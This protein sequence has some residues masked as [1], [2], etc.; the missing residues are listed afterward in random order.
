MRISDISQN[1]LFQVTGIVLAVLISFIGIRMLAYWRSFVFRPGRYRARA[2]VTTSQLRAT[3]VPFVK[4]QWTTKGGLGSTEVILRGLRQ[5]EELAR[6]DPGFYRRF[7][8][9]EVVTENRE[10]ARLIEQ[11]FA[12][13]PL[14]PPTCVVTPADYETPNGTQLKA[15]QMHY[16][17]ELRRMGHNRKP[18]RTFIIHFDEDTLMVPAEFRKMIA[19]LAYTDKSLLTGPIYYP[20]EYD[21]AS[22]L[23]RA[24]EASRPIT[25]FECRHVM[26][27]GVPLHIHGSNLAVEETFENRLGWDIGLV[28]GVPFVAEDYMF[29]MDAF[30]REGREAFGWHGCVALE[31]PPFSF[32]SVFRQRYRWVF[33]VLQGMSVDTLLPDFAKLPRRLRMKVIWGTRY[34]IAT[35]AAGSFVGALALVYVPFWLAVA[36]SNMAAGK[37]IGI[38][39]KLAAWFALV[40]FM[41]LGSNIVG[42]WANTLDAGFPALRRVTEITRAVSI[43]PFV[44]MME[45]L[46]ALKAVVQWMAG[47]R[48]MHW[49]VT[50]STKAADDV[51]NGRSEHSGRPLAETVTEALVPWR[52]APAQ[53]RLL[54]A[55]CST[56]TAVLTVSVYLGMPLLAVAQAVTLSLSADALFAASGVIVLVSGILAVIWRTSRP[57]AAHSRRRPAAHAVR[58]PQPTIL[59]AAADAETAS[60]G[61]QALEAMFQVRS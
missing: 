17:T 46:A 1:A 26:E 25:C 9:A 13:S 31:Q 6:E 19:H 4:V 23:A 7:L 39:W 45:N 8:S 32:P 20:L 40:G 14:A 50:P 2:K 56:A 57:A 15:R 48:Q 54:P 37:P 10:Q 16:L 59:V 47:Y 52:A 43:T 36:A 41:W 5:L 11:A 18:G 27:M 55:L 29:G 38:S 61:V 58:Q 53:T 60:Y 28:A 35:Y 12:D 33:G 34:R 21:D 3:P 44:G 30:L 42:G 49:E 24:T 51:V 22:K